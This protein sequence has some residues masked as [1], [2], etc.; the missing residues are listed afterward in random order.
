MLREAEWWGL[1]SDYMASPEVSFCRKWGATDYELVRESTTFPQ[2]QTRFYEQH[3][4]D[5]N[6]S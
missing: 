5:F 1:S 4:I 6:T 2:F 3:G